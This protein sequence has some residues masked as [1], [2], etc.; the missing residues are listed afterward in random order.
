ME[1]YQSYLPFRSMELNDGIANAF[2]A[3]LGLGAYQICAKLFKES[4]NVSRVRK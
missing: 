1:W 4:T 3:M 2:G